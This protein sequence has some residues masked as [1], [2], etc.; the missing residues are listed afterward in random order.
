LTLP[1]PD[2]A[3]AEHSARLSKHIAGEIRAAGGW[4]PFSR[5]MDLA[6]YAPGLGYY[7][8]G[9][10]KFGAPGDFVTAPELS[11][12]FAQTLATQV[13]QIMRLSAPSIVEAGPGSGILAAELLL[14]L[15]LRNALP[16]RYDLLEL[17]GELRARQ[18]ASLEARAPHLT[19]RV[20]WLERLPERFSGVVIANEV[21]DAMPMER[22]AWQA[23]GMFARG[24]ALD[25]QGQF[26]WEDRPAPTLLAEAA[27]AL[28]VEPPYVSE[29]GPA[30]QAWVASWGAILGRG[31]LLLIDYGFPAREYYHPQRS[32]GTLMCHYRH[33]A[34][35]NP[36]FLPGLNDITAHVDF[37]AM[38]AAGVD[39][40]LEFYG[41]TSQARFLLNCGITDVLARVS[42]DD[43]TRYMPLA[44]SAQTLL[45]PSEMGELFKVLALGRGIEGPLIGFA[46]GDRGHTL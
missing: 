29:L 27:P 42:R 41:Y 18:R 2:A 31:A 16:T 44:A 1:I 33:H 35:D 28:G 3:A 26:C 36:F 22:V 10:H 30:A 5:Y 13:E 11:P 24:V 23:S 21:L 39:A 43:H 14:E 46:S 15:E 7:G 32:G 19:A 34:H 8:G 4:L 45:N 6:L 12:L 9:S 25:A 37:T 38:A 17:S 40:G 20:F